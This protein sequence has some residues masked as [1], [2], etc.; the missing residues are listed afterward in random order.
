[1]SNRQTH[2]SLVLFA[3]F[4]LVISMA[5]CGEQAETVQEDVEEN[6]ETAKEVAGTFIKMVQLAV[7]G[8]DE[9]LS[10]SVREG[11][12]YGVTGVSGAGRWGIPETAAVETRVRRS[13]STLS[14][15]DQKQVIDGFVKLKQ[16]TVDSD[17]AGAERADYKTFCEDSYTRN[18]YD[19]YVEL[20][21][22]AFVSMGKDD[23][24]ENQM[25]HMGPQFLPWHRYYL[26]R[27]EADMQEVLGDPDFALPYWDWEDCEAGSGDGTNPCPKIFDTDFL[28]SHGG[29]E[30][31]EMGVTGYLVDQGFETYIWS[32]VDENSMFNTDSLN[33]STKP[34]QRAV[35]CNE[36]TDGR[37]PTAEDVAGIFDRKVYD[38]ES[39]DTCN[40]DQDVS[41]RQYIEGYKQDERRALCILAGCENHG[42]GHIYIGGDMGSGG[43]PSNDPMF[44]LHHAN[45][46]RLWAMWQDNNRASSD[47]ATDYGNPDYPDDWRG[48]IFNFDEVRADE[49]FD[50]RA[51]GFSYDTNEK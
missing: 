14:D 21:Y 35:G 13:W 16:T 24:P 15:D 11:E 41:F 51:L 46:D 47:T 49:M 34:L 37:L 36:V 23:M 18:L 31:E 10:M 50:Y 26:L 39:Y 44:F 7:K 43:A 25:A 40:T 1:M 12:G 48:E 19:F 6:V 3:A 32:Q 20:H 4:L 8:C 30:D 42:L 9:V 5:G 38:A 29:C 45:I 33:C 22:S 17:A 28:G 2:I 27:I